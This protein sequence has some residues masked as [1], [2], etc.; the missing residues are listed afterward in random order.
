[1][2]QY[3]NFK[4]YCAHAGTFQYLCDGFFSILET[5][6][7]FWK[8]PIAFNIIAGK[9]VGDRWM[10]LETDYFNEFYGKGGSLAK[11]HGPL[12]LFKRMKGC[13]SSNYENYKNP[14]PR[15]P[16]R[17]TEHSNGFVQWLGQLYFISIEMSIRS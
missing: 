2:P 8:I 15:L 11:I 13:Y 17:R 5:L 12:F 16:K 9:S 3:W 4:N 6:N 1:M 7:V 10:V 14:F